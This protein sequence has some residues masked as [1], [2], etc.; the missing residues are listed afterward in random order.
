[1]NLTVKKRNGELSKPFSDWFSPGSIF[2]SMFSEL[3]NRF[4]GQ[5][6]M[7]MPSANIKETEKEFMIELAAPGLSRR[8]FQVELDDQLLTIR[9]EKK[10][11]KE[12]EEANYARREYAYNSFSRSFGLP[13]NSV[14]DK[15]SAR[16]VDGVLKISIP[17]KEESL[18]RP[19]K[20]IT[21][22]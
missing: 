18:S 9:A 12:E 3:E 20:Q 1:M 21:V 17:K 15:I 19:K 5:M 11:E 4:P 14:A 16:Y 6:G 7:T 13:E 2:G 8:D 10:E 22:A